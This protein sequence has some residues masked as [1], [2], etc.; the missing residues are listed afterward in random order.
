M[1]LSSGITST[2]TRKRLGGMVRPYFVGLLLLSVAA[3]PAAGQITVGENVHVSWSNSELPH[4]EVLAA[5]DPADPSRMLVCSMAYT[6]ERTFATIVYRSG[7]GGSTWSEVLRD[8][9]PNSADPACLFGPGNHAYFLTQAL[10]R[11]WL[12]RSEDGGS[13]WADPIV[14]PGSGIDRP[15]LAVDRS[16]GQFRD[17]V[18][19]SAT[20][21]GFG[22][23]GERAS[24]VDFFVSEDSA[25]SFAGPHTRLELGGGWVYG[26]GNSVILSNGNIIT[27]FGVSRSQPGSKEWQTTTEDSSSAMLKVTINEWG[28]SWPRF[29]QRTTR[30]IGEWHMNRSVASA[31]IP[32][33]AV[34]RA[35]G[36]FR[37][38]LYV[39]WADERRGQL[40]VYT[41]YS[42]DGG[43]TWTAPN[44]ISESG[45]VGLKSERRDAVLP[46]VAVNGPGVVAVAWADRREERDSLGW[47]YRLSA[48]LDGGETWLRSVAVSEASATFGGDED[49]TLEGRAQPVTRG[50]DIPALRASVMFGRFFG[51]LGDTGGIAVGPEGVFFPFWVDNRTGV[52]QLWTAPV[53]VRG[54]VARHGDPSLGRMTNVSDRV[55]LRISEES[56]DRREDLVTIGM[57]LRNNSRDTIHGPVKLRI[58]ELTGRL[59]SMRI[60]GSENGLESEGA[61]LDLSGG[62][63]VGLLPP[64]EE[65]DVVR[66]QVR[67]GEPL[68]LP[69]AG[70]VRELVRIEGLLLA[71]VPPSEDP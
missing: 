47:R 44:L 30:T 14:L 53:T 40:D 35:Q 29:P 12:Y 46:V 48:S 15:Y 17:R 61:V 3:R 33:I 26:M 52:F 23:G 70:F 60:L 59:G 13:R 1:E 37:D 22:M 32:A 18:Y 2:L 49:W 31:Q 38:R 8:T 20:G 65:S 6:A 36:P 57:R 24:G 66:I 25:Q 50:P 10:A 54:I 45:S 43:N 64:G 67:V 5:S 68:P 62:L 42:S 51:G 21:T 71:G 4:W 69:R 9:H 27:V 39:T 7:D 16:D 34:D 58:L 28:G 55:S 19:I 41:S 56:Y 63:P 11:I